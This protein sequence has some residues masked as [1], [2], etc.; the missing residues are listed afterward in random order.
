MNRLKDA[1][2][3]VG[4]V[5]VFTCRLCG[6]PRPSILWTGPDHSQISHSTQT[7]CDF[8]DDGLARLQVRLPVYQMVT[9]HF[10]VSHFAISHLA[11]S[12]FAV[13]HYLTLNQTPNPIP[14]SNPIPDSNHKP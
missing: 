10:A 6:K 12:H 8:S 4:E 9:V 7:L 5:A 1:S 3:S 2:V 11:V 14:N 13:S